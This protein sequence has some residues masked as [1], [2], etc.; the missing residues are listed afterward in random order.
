MLRFGQQVRR[1][2]LRP[3]QEDYHHGTTGKEIDP[4]HIQS[5]R[6]KLEAIPGEEIRDRIEAI[7]YQAAFEE[8]EDKAEKLR[9]CREEDP[10]AFEEF[11]K[12]Q[13]HA[14]MNARVGREDGKEGKEESRS[15]KP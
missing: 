12:A 3:E 6:E 5:L 10:E 4:S 7:G 14:E 1:D 8:L 11:I 15:E 13:R 9:L 2:I